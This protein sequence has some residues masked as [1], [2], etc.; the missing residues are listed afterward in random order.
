MIRAAVLCS[1]FHIIFLLYA[2]Y[3]FFLQVMDAAKTMVEGVPARFDLKVAEVRKS[4]KTAS[5]TVNLTKAM[6]CEGLLALGL[7]VKGALKPYTRDCIRVQIELITGGKIQE[8][9]IN[10]V[11]YNV[12]C[13][14]VK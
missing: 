4:F 6:I 2:L 14:H 12:A 1:P 8:S 11:L 10:Q 3:L 9:L 13:K 5:E 7:N